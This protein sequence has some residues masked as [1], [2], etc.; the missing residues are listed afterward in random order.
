[1]PDAVDKSSVSWLAA[2]DKDM[3]YVDFKMAL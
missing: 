1:M 2:G 3:D